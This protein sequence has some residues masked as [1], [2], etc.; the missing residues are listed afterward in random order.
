MLDT[1][2][3]VGGE[4]EKS[5]V[6]FGGEIIT[7]FRLIKLKKFNMDIYKFRN[8]LNYYRIETKLKLPYCLDLEP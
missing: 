3:L 5:S 8:C 7:T 1:K 2:P 4:I 6:L